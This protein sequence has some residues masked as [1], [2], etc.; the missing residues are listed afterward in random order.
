MAFQTR[1]LQAFNEEM[2]RRSDAAEPR[3][4]KT[5]I[6]K[7]AGASSGAATHWFNGSNGMD[8]A[9][10][11][12]VA[13]LL[14][15]NPQW[16]YDG[17]GPKRPDSGGSMASSAPAPWP[18]PH[19]P[20]SQ[21]RAL[22][23]AQLNALQGALALAIAQLKLGIEVAA[24]QAPAHFRRP[25]V[26]LDTAND[27]F[28]VHAGKHTPAA[29]EG[30]Q[31]MRQ[32]ERDTRCPSDTQTRVFANVGPGGPPAVDDRFEDVP[33]LAD[34]RLAAGAGIENQNEEQTGM[35]PFRRSFLEA[36]G[37]SNGKAKVV[38][39][40]GDSMDPVIR[41]GAALL[42]VPDESLTLRSLVAGGVYAI[43]YDG[44]MLVKT[45]ARDKLTRHWVARSFNPMY[46]DIPLEGGT[47][48]R[49]LGQVVWAGARLRTHESGQWMPA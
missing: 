10:C 12:K 2:A 41:D 45:V 20:E 32:A 21:V 27:E 29:W 7:A 5:D 3:L 6:W 33:E 36:M 11:L 26:D 25:P 16:L 43:N 31:A 14:R 13:P 34:V 22:P 8:M 24:P 46:P 47:S 15:V 28:P 49:V 23:P 17:T 37:A 1:I 9:T 42:V 48:I 19:I 18:F 30:A 40:K 4:T 44:K 39:A 35:I 38:Y